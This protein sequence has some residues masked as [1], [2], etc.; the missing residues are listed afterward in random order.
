MLSTAGVAVLSGIL[1][2]AHD[3]SDSASANTFVV[4]ADFKK[5]EM[6]AQM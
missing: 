1:G 2:I 5:V 4:P 6:P 3:R